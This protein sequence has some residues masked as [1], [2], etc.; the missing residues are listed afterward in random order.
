MEAGLPWMSS[1]LEAQW[2]HLNWEPYSY[3]RPG[4]G[5]SAFAED[6]ERYLNNGRSDE[7][8]FAALKRVKGEVEDRRDCVYVIGLLIDFTFD[9]ATSFGGSPKPRSSRRRGAL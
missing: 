1:D 9:L 4:G 3:V 6:V 5:A 8:L 7:D 2:R